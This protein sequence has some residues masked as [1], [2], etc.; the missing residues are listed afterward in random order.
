MKN[1]FSILS[2]IAFV[3]SG[4]FAKGVPNT[5]FV[6]SP[7]ERQLNFIEKGFYDMPDEDA[8][9][10]EHYLKSLIRWDIAITE[11]LSDN[12]PGHSHIFHCCVNKLLGRADGFKKT[13]NTV[14]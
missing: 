11:E 1:S 12:A 10:S 2:V 7:A 3:H 5:D 4:L 13:T 9:F 8:D 14:C 6:I